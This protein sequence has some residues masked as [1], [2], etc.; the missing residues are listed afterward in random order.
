MINS[1][2]N[3]GMQLQDLESKIKSLKLKWI[4]NL[5]DDNYMAAWKSYI[6]PKFNEKFSQILLYNMS[7]GYYP[8]HFDKF[9]EDLFST[10]A[11][12]H[13]D[14]PKNPEEICKQIIWH[15]T[16]IPINNQ[17]QAYKQWK[18]SGIFFIQDLLD[19]K[20]LF[21]SKQEL[22]NKYNFT[23]KHLEYQSLMSAIPINWKQNV[24][25]NGNLNK[26]YYVFR[27]CKIRI[28]KMSKNIVEV[29]TR[30]LYWH[31]IQKIS[32][33][34]TSEAKW[35]E[36]GML[37]LS[38]E[39]WGNI[40][41]ADRKLTRES[42]IQNFQFKVTH[43]ILACGYNLAIW[44]IRDNNMCQ[45]CLQEIDTI[46]HFLVECEKTK[47]FWDSI[48]NWWRINMK[49]RF[50]I[51]LYEYIFGI[52]NDEKDVVINQLN[53]LLLMGRYYIY[54]CKQKEVEMELFNFLLDC[55]RRL[56]IERET[57]AV[58]N[59]ID[60]FTKLWSELLENM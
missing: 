34:P 41:T 59:E 45:I 13:V 10:W 19:D 8:K 15:N 55:K 36:R 51:F 23:I 16:F 50:D 18:D 12:I 56:L 52:P 39:D 40:Y 22:E 58:A 38:E 14:E 17:R 5:F 30:D 6:S 26:N 20:G 33:R 60:R 4:N 9:Y 44:K 24:K 21:M 25:K 48:I 47:I 11:E 35:L 2:D 43:R 57:R 3:G 7:K 1:W 53:F 49:V 31:L 29:T 54:V 46:E 42:K 37:D 28:G 27:E 32:L